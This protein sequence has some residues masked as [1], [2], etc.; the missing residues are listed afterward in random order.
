MEVLL[1]V[2]VSELMKTCFQIFPLNMEK[3]PI[4]SFFSLETKEDTRS[5]F[6]PPRILLLLLETP[7]CFQRLWH[8]EN[9]SFGALESK[10]PIFL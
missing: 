4:I 8:S 2:Y 5:I 9:W 3:I 7:R 1:F 10:W 6:S